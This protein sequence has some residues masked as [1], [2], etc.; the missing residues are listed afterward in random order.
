MSA[1]TCI[2]HKNNSKLLSSFTCIH[3][4]SLLPSPNCRPS[5]H[6]F[7]A[8]KY[9]FSKLRVHRAV[10]NNGIDFLPRNNRRRSS[11]NSPPSCNHSE[12]TPF[13][14]FAGEVGTNLSE[15]ARA[16]ARSSYSSRLCTTICL[17]SPVAYAT[18]AATRDDI[19]CL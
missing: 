18:L 3:P 7:H 12:S 13:R 10:S 5:T 1:I 4:S 8:A 17:P 2:Y 19:L 11:S 15:L 9:P 14:P 6:R 16:T